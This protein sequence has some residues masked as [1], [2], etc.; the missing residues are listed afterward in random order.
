MIHFLD[1][2]SRQKLCYL[3]AKG[4][5]LL[6]VEAAQSLL[7]W[8]GA[9]LDPQGVL[10]DFPRYAW[11]LRGFPW[12]DVFVS[13]EEVDERAFLFRGEGGTNAHRLP[14]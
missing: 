13:A 3:F 11:H 14:L 8:L 2:S 7:H 4:P 12:E 10:G 9:Q 6:L 5:A 1:E